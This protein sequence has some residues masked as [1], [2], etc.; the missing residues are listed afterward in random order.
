MSEKFPDAIRD[1]LHDMLM[2]QANGDYAGTK[3]FLDKYG[4]V[5]PQLDAAIAK[6]KRSPDRYHSGLR[7]E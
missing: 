7:R 2:L 6:I 1:L 4:V 3:A 5:S